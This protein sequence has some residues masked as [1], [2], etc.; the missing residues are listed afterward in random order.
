MSEL[1]GFCARVPWLS[2][3]VICLLARGLAGR[4]A[5]DWK[6]DV[7]KKERKVLKQF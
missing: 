5:Q 1:A 7:G 2:E 6:A 4:Q 3:E